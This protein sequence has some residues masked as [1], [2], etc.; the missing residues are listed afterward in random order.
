MSALT[1]AATI[2][3]MDVGE[4]PGGRFQP[5]CVCLAYGL[6]VHL[7]KTNSPETNLMTSNKCNRSPLDL[8]TNL[9]AFNLGLQNTIILP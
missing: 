1:L 6:L 4:V 9:F 3:G 8:G 5:C 7:F 2:R